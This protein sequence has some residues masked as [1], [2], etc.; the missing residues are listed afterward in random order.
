MLVRWLA[1]AVLMLAALHA[2]PALAGDC[3]A[4]TGRAIEGARV[5]SAEVAPAGPMTTPVPLAAPATLDLPAFC[6]VKAIA[7]GS[8][9]FE[10][11]LPLDGWN[12]RLLSVGSG[13]FGGDLPLNALAVG[14]QKG[15]AVTGND[16]GHQ[17]ADPSWMRDPVK[18]RL[19][20]HSATHL[21]TA[22]SKALV[23]A[24]Y[25][26]PARWAYFEGCSTGGAQAMTEAQAYPDDYD[27]LVAGAP[28]MSYAHLMLSFLWGL[29]ATEP[30]GAPI[31]PDKLQVLHA[32]VL[33]ACDHDDGLRDGLISDPE[34]C[35]F[36]VASIICGPE[37]AA[38]NACLTPAEAR[39]ARLIYSGPRNRRTGASIYP[40]FAYGSEADAAAGASLAAYGWGA[41]QG[42]LAQYFAIPLLRTMVYGDPDWDWRTFDWD[43]D[44]AE[45]DRR[46]GGDITALSPDL[47]R[48][49]ARG[50][51]LLIHQGW[52]DQFNG[53]D[54]PIEYRRRVIDAFAETGG[55]GHA[56][57]AVDGFMRVFMAP[58]MGH[59]AGGPGFADFD[60]LSAVQA[61]VET[62]R[63]PDRL[64]ASRPSA[65]G[66]T[67]EVRPICAYPGLARYV[68][69][70]SPA[71]PSS[72]RC[73]RGTGASRGGRP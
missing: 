8:I 45:V 64:L 26:A 3:Q 49:R 24:Y 13:G 62:G 31:P 18:V 44:V 48:F 60:A 61:W 32:A 58:G 41:I 12:N 23:A 72:F 28:G 7:A 73:V 70:G 59:C 35:R 5:V 33:A 38:R 6:R 57:A 22:P 54:L 56:E 55:R 66:T 39:T 30:P 34:T 52:G 40:G 27:G 19:W 29:K 11:W 2:A 50:G 36:D 53:Q 68:G 4:L 21:V 67:P 17:G 69:A 14:L 10:V 63:A 15:F 25:G 43:R 51:K 16:T 20:G 65:S 37:D 47:E 46:V 1:C 9:G 71:D 42:P